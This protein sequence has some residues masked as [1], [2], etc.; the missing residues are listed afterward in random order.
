MSYQNAVPAAAGGPEIVLRRLRAVLYSAVLAAVL[1]PLYFWIPMAHGTL[2]GMAG[3]AAVGALLGG[4]QV[5]RLRYQVTSGQLTVRQLY[6]RRQSVDLTRLTSVSAPSRP[7]TFWRSRGPWGWLELRDARGS[8]ARL[9]FYGTPRA[10]LQRMLAVLGPY[11][12]ADG[13]SRT[14]L[15]TEALSGELWWP[16]PH[17]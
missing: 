12:M 11:V 13:V 3:G 9:N 5:A 2:K 1:S 16:W 7:Q 6:S 10:Q 4:S 8:V 14:G 15:V 17:R